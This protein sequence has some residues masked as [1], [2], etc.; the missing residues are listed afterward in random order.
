MYAT[1][2]PAR[3]LA[4]H[5]CTAHAFDDSTPSSACATMWARSQPRTVLSSTSASPRGRPD[6]RIKPAMVGAA[7]AAS[8][9]ALLGECRELLG[10]QLGL[11]RLRQLGE[12][13]VH[14]VV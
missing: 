11:Q 2:S 1:G 6:S 14:D 9:S 8:T 12:V 4:N 13:T 7:D 5:A 10:L 3:R